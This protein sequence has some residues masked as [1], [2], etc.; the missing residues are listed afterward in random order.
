MGW[1]QDEAIAFEC[2]CEAITHMI[3]ICS[4]EI[5]AE[6]ASAEPNAMRIEYLQKKILSYVSERRNLH[7]ESHVEIARIREQYGAYIRTRGHDWSAAI[8][9]A[10]NPPPIGVGAMP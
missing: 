5:A 8:A 7:V 9:A 2:A 1:T 3:A 6:E 10:S 4:S